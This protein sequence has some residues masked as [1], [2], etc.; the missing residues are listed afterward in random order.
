MEFPI[1]RSPFAM[2]LTGP[3]GSG[4]SVFIQKVLENAR[5]LTQRP[6]AFDLIIIVYRCEQVLH[7]ALKRR[8]EQNFGT[9]VLLCR[10]KLPLKD[11]ES[12]QV[13][14][15]RRILESAAC[16]NP[17][18]IFDDGS[19]DERFLSD[20]F[21]KYRHH[22]PINIIVVTHNLFGDREASGSLL[23]SL[24]RN[25]THLVLMKQIRDRT[26]IRT[27]VYQLQPNK[28]KASQLLD[29]I[30]KDTERPFSHF[31][32]DLTQETPDV[33]R[34]KTNIF[35]INPEVRVFP[36]AMKGIKMNEHVPLSSV[37]D[38]AAESAE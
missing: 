21:T 15:L 2:I 13:G 31:L 10:D 25:A 36:D 1:L 26:M 29:A 5:R 37:I 32:I 27:L 18:I 28:R 30:I 38:N 3:S 23:R 9:P 6:E 12:S 19:E 17:I 8:M 24:N 35:S 14:A 4:K 11:G 20:L 34:Y 33:L 16:L 7:D 22:F